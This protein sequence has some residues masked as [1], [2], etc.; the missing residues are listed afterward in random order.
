MHI[1]IFCTVI[2]LESCSYLHYKEINVLLEEVIHLF[3][4]DGLDLSLTVN[5]HITG[6]LRHT[7]SDQCITLI[8]YLPG[9]VTG[10]F[11]DL[12]PLDQTRTD[13]SDNRLM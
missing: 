12:G 3:L 13:W 2:P 10:C 5:L 6:S 11:I 9:Q 7:P 8:G 1:N 4:K